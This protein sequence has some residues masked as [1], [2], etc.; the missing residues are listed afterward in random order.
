MTPVSDWKT[1]VFIP[2][3]IY[4]SLRVHRGVRNIFRARLF[5]SVYFSSGIDKVTR[6]YS[7]RLN[8]LSRSE[9]IIADPKL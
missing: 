2:D 3:Y 9:I 4:F 5:S 7:R 1:P 8:L 6:R